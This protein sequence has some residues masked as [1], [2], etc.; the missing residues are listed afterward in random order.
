MGNGVTMPSDSRASA[1][2]GITPSSR[3]VVRAFSLQGAGSAHVAASHLAVAE[4]RQGSFAPAGRCLSSR[5]RAV[6]TSRQGLPRICDQRGH[7]SPRSVANEIENIKSFDYFT[8]HSHSMVFHA[9]SEGAEA[10]ALGPRFADLHVR[11]LGGRH[12]HAPAVAVADRQDALVAD[13]P[14]DL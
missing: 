13:R 12:D 1:M 5:A 14:G 8:T 6:G 4:L 9:A 7:T 2:S 11:E 10:H 3:N